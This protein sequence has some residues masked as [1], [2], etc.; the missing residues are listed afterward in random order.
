VPGVAWAGELE[1]GET[2]P[3]FNV[4]GTRGTHWPVTGAKKHWQRTLEQLLMAVG[5]PRY[6]MGQ[7]F[8]GARLRFPSAHGRD[9][10]N[11][12]WIL[13]KALGDALVN[14]GVIPDDTAAQ[15][16][17]TGVEF[18]RERGP[19]RTTIVLWLIEKED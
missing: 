10:G 19:D 8:A 7:A 9:S 1:Y 6:G 3:S 18:E 17:F 13:E 16:C 14:A 5:V 4:V 11:F 15:F 2:P 12:S